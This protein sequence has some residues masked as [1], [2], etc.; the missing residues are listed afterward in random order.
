MPVVTLRY[1][2][3]E[4]QGEFDAAI[5]G[6]KAFLALWEIDQRLRSLLKHG[7]PSSE[8]GQLA[9]EIRQMIPP[10]MLDI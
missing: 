1:T 5:N 3:P 2:L 6:R 7:E 9:E 8:T 10:E 4:E